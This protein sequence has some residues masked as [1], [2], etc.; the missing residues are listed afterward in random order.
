LAEAINADP[1]AERPTEATLD[2]DACDPISAIGRCHPAL[3]RAAARLEAE[4]QPEVAPMTV[5]L[6]ALGRALVESVTDIDDPALR[7]VG[8]T[9][10]KILALGGGPADAIATGFIEA[11]CGLSVTRPGEVRRVVELL[12]T[13][14]QEYI[15]AWD[16][17]TGAETP[18]ITP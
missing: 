15:R 5:A 17:F 6:G 10:E 1:H 14:A 8:V 11:I 3:A 12:G 13:N 16:E 2:V 4:W 9:V 18:G 7:R